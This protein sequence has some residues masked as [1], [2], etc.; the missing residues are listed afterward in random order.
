MPPPFNTQISAMLA[1]M[2]QQM[3]EAETRE[4]RLSLLVERAPKNPRVQPP[5]PSS[6]PISAE[7]PVLQASATL[8]DFCSWDEAWQDYAICQHLATQSRETPVSAVRQAFD[9]EIQRF[10]RLGIICI[11]T[12][13]DVPAIITSVKAYIRRQRNPLLDRIEFYQRHQQRGDAPSYPDKLMPSV[14]F[15]EPTCKTC[16]N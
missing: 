7:C 3:Q 11:P 16:S 5:I 2:Q 13:A 6:K 4:H 12:S 14:L 1:L 8:A 9:E 15:S 10:L